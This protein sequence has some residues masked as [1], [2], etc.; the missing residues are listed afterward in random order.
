MAIAD[1]EYKFLYIDMGC[2]G[3]VSDGGVFNKCSF[4][5]AMN[6]RALNLPESSTLRGR[7]MNLPFVLVADDEAVSWTGIDCCRTHL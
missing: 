2:N 6:N 4:G 1:A 7:T 5:V 3:R